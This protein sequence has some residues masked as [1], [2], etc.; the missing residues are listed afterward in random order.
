MMLEIIRGS[1]IIEKEETY[2]QPTLKM[3]IITILVEMVYLVFT[4]IPISYIYTSFN[5]SCVYITS[6][7]LLSIWIGEYNF[8]LDLGKKDISEARNLDQQCTRKQVNGSEKRIKYS[9]EEFVINNDGP[10]PNILESETVIESEEDNSSNS[11]KSWEEIS[12]NL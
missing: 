10:V 9:S 2:N 6:I 4:I 7:F 8:I 3:K 11:E 5:I 12:T 1:G